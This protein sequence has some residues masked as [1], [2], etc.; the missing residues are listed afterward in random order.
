MDMPPS[1]RGIFLFGPFRLDPGRRALLRDGIRVAVPAPLFDTLLTLVEHADRMVEGDELLEAAWRG[2]AAE[3]LSA[4]DIAAAL[5]KL[6]EADEHDE[7][8]ISTA[9]RGGYR[10]AAAVRF[11]PAPA[12]ELRAGL[13][14]ESGAL[15][16]GTIVVQP[17]TPPKWR[18]QL[19]TGG[20]LALV[21]VVAG[22]VAWRMLPVRDGFAPPPQ[23]IAVLAFAPVSS[24][25][26]EQPIADGVSA[27]LI[28]SLR[29]VKG[30]SV[31]PGSA[32]LAIQ[33]GETSV[34]A[35]AR[36]LGVEAV[37]EGNVRLYASRV[38]LVARLSHGVAGKPYWTRS[39]DQA[40]G[41]LPKIEQRII[42]DVTASLHGVKL[43]GPS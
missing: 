18:R 7:S 34:T 19:V 26:R 42:A 40:Q 10:F 11:L 35:T 28:A 13:F 39:Y 31:A 12:A 27:N 17:R 20:V 37:L 29:Q 15:I 14:D 2:R 5:R 23:S 32:S 33:S 9:A 4:E 38:R 36:R 3:A 43:Q 25:P 41:D 16:Q 30:V 6:L 8:Y 21:V 24:D 1:N 22:F